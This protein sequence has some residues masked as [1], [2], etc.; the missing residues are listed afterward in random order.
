MPREARR[1]LQRELVLRLRNLFRLKKRHRSLAELAHEE[2]RLGNPGLALRIGRR[3]LEEDA[4]NPALMA[5]LAAALREDGS[6]E[7]AI[8]CAKRAV[9]LRPADAR[10][11]EQLGSLLLDTGSAQA[12]LPQLEEWARLQPRSPR[13]LLAL[14]EAHMALGNGGGGSAPPQ[15]ASAPRPRGAPLRLGLGGAAPK[16]R[17]PARARAPLPPG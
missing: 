12:A 7:E 15:R 16:A 14:A 4:N 10:S 1:A 11:R 6:T 13:A 5:A 17:P 9:E 8:A 2:L 3:A